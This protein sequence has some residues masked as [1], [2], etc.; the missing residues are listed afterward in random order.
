LAVFVNYVA[1]KHGEL[2]ISTTGCSLLVG[3]AMSLSFKKEPIT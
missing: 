3:R 1:S 2:E